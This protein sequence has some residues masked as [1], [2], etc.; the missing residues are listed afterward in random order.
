[1]GIGRSPIVVTAE[2][3]PFLHIHISLLVQPCDVAT[4]DAMILTDATLDTAIPTA[5]T[6]VTVATTETAGTIAIEETT[7]TA[8]IEMTAVMIIEETIIEIEG[9]IIGIEGMIDEMIETEETAARDKNRTFGLRY[10]TA[11]EE[12]EINLLL[13]SAQE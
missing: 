12:Y 11:F 8:T 2:S 3:M 9:M 5:T 1:M 13:F 10:Y 6:G 7:G 4:T